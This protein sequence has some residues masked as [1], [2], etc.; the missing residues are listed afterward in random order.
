MTFR[1][2]VRE[3]LLKYLFSRAADLVV[4]DF[5]G[6]ALVFAPHFDDEVLG[7][8]GTIAMLIHAGIDVHVWFLTDGG[9]SHSH[10][11][12]EDNL[13]ALR[14]S[15]CY[16][17]TSELGIQKKNIKTWGF[18][19]S[20]LATRI[21]QVVQ[22]S[23][24]EF[25]QIR[26][27]FVFAPYRH[28]GPADHEAAHAICVNLVEQARHDISILEYPVWV[29]HEWPWTKVEVGGRREIPARAIRCITSNFTRFRHFDSKVDIAKFLPR[30]KKALQEYRS[31]MTRIMQT[32]RWKTLTDI[33]A[34]TFLE[35]CLMPY[36]VFSLSAATKRK[37]SGR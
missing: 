16:R 18:P 14:T 2:A 24:P 13:T 33:G 35:N 8:G 17:A 23:K 11:I 12:P 10:L 31:Q 27:T 30:K 20:S 15:E 4:E 1:R 25:D 7:C 6:S 22:A 34:G 26:P 37:I 5:Q 28:D 21:A 19:D 3:K 32:S 36:E 29:W 9:K